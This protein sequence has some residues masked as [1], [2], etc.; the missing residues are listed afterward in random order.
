MPASGQKKRPRSGTRG[1]AR[2]KPSQTR[3]KSNSARRRVG[4]KRSGG[5]AKWLKRWRGSAY[6]KA[7]YAL[8]VLTLWGFV[9]IG[10]V[11]FYYALDL[12]DTSNLW[13]TEQRPSVTI[14]DYQNRKLLT[15]GISYGVPVTIN[16]LPHYLPKAVLA[17]EDRRFYHHIGVDLVG[18]ARAA[19]ANW[20]EGKVVQGGS[21]IT[22]QL[23][24][25]LFLNPERRMKRKIQEL[26]LALWLEHRFTK[27]QILS[28]YLNRVYLGAGTYG[29]EAAAQ[30]YFG[31]SARDVSLGEAAIL[32]GLLKAPSRYAPTRNADRAQARAETVLLKMV[33]AG[34]ITD[35]ERWRAKK[36]P[37]RYVENSATIGL[38]Y[39]ADW[40]MEQLPLLIGD[41]DADLI[42]KT[43]LDKE[44]Q[45]QAEKAVR[46]TLERDG[47]KLKFSEG[48][49]VSMAADGAVR[50]MVGGRSY[51][52][53]QFNRVTH[54]KRQ[55]GSA[56]KPFVFLSALE[57]GLRP[58]DLVE[59]APIR[60]GNWAPKNFNET[61]RGMISLKEALAQSAN[62]A[63]VRLAERV[64][65]D[66]VVALAK[67]LGVS[68]KLAANRS[69]PLGTSEV[70]LLELTAAYTPFANGGARI[71]TH[72]ITQI[73]TADGGRL[74]DRRPSGLG[75][76]IRPQYVGDMNDMLQEVM[77]AGTGRKANLG[78][79]AAAG[80]TGTSQNNRD[81]WFVG[82]TADLVT[83]VWVGN[84][85]NS[86]MGRVT[87]GRV[88][89]VIWKDFMLAAHRELPLRPLPD[90]RDPM[91]VAQRPAIGAK[92]KGALSRFFNRL[93]SD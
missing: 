48:A 23:A 44:L 82:Y 65:P 83:G 84:D 67:R 39:F 80:K 64:G 62:S 47:A 5:I 37:P 12:P 36:T 29:V 79:R 81:A 8:A 11:A 90:F 6:A 35:G 30:R 58:G 4:R 72:G 34:Y 52:S 21:T 77:R 60:I 55:P 10:G 87:G 89:T 71:A 38:N 69:L 32:A 92:D 46:L 54:A 2:R 76:V 45:A 51:Q 50:A 15:R 27:D 93:F 41:I 1:S 28:L 25:N 31:K 14:V 85:D 26:M 56:F 86:P 68:S 88:P 66:Q 53:S 59:D 70:T 16:E 20:Q 13:A 43:T 61:Y 57:N 33:E 3:R 17:T 63:A 78:S 75:S 24:K 18:L 42:V 19:F 40:V 74:Y 9:A 22:Q 7:T 91:L 49:L 73:T